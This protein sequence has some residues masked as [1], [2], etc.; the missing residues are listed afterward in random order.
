VALAALE[1]LG[2][3]PTETGWATP[4]EPAP[5]IGRREALQANAQWAKEYV[6]PWVHRRLT[7]RSSGD[8]RS[9]K[10]PD[11]APLDPS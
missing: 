7:G 4:L 10:R 1:A 3:T 2:H 6:G 9:A 8:Q 11:V 5:P